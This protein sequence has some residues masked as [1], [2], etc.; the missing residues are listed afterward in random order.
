[1]LR[2]I[3]VSKAFVAPLRA[4]AI[5]TKCIRN[6]SAKLEIPDDKEQ[7]FGRRKEEIEAEE[8]GFERFNSRPIIPNSNAGTKEN[9]ILVSGFLFICTLV[10]NLTNILFLV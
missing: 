9:P 8:Q 10:I 5:Q 1:M 4:S 3:H 6:F 7:Q 2:L